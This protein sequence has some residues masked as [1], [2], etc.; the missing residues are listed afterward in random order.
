[1]AIADPYEVAFA[2]LAASQARKIPRDPEAVTAQNRALREVVMAMPRPKRLD[3]S[4]VAF[5]KMLQDHS[6]IRMLVNQMIDQVPK[7]HKTVDS[8][9]ELLL[10]LNQIVR[11]APK[12]NVDKD[13]RNAFPM[14]ML[15][16]H[17]MITEAGYAVFRMAPMND[18]LRGVLTAWCG[19]LDS[20]ESAHVLTDTPEGWFQGY[21]LPRESEAF[22]K[23]AWHYND[24][25]S[26]EVDMDQKHGGFDCFNA[27]FHR[28]IKPATRPLDGC[29]DPHVVVSP[30]DGTIYHIAREVALETTFWIKSQPYSL[31]DMLNGHDLAGSY[32]GGDVLQ[33]YL[34]G[35]DYHRW[36]APVS[37]RIL[38]TDV[39]PALMFSNLESV[40]NDISGVGSQGYYTSVNTRGLCFIEADHKPLGVVCVMPVGITEI[41]SIQHTVARG[42]RVEKG[43]EIG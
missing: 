12:W 20:P 25:D 17:M 6:P 14:S 23:S 43:D 13:K 35:S 41:S 3:P 15:F 9:E 18:A 30:N 31:H 38:H 40:G 37:G 16:T 8:V 28:E 1:M 7:R 32:A 19:Y 27:F 11:T 10:Q 36:H 22:E 34:Q 24:L 4:V 2:D 21:K 39:I 5:E 33:S 29:D 42:D 26:Y